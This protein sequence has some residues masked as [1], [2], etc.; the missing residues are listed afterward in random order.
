MPIGAFN[1][2]DI[3][4]YEGTTCDIAR[5]QKV[6]WKR[7][8]YTNGNGY[9]A[10]NKGN[11]HNDPF[12]PS[13][14]IGRMAKDGP[15]TRHRASVENHFF[16]NTQNGIIM[17]SSACRVFPKVHLVYNGTGCEIGDVP[18]IPLFLREAVIDFASEAT[19]RIR[20]AKPDGKGY[21][22][23]WQI[24]DKRLNRDQQYGMG[25]GSWYRANDRV[26]SMSTAEK[27]DLYEYLNRN[28]WQNGL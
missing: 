21:A 15:V 17:F 11:N 7:N 27:S 25:Q 18:F 13:N 12:M 19:L 24:Y 28:Q 22:A 5:S 23:L 2:R 20:M 3:Y 9:F 1:I 10:D 6:W 26:K 8:Y 14:T 16:A 4:L